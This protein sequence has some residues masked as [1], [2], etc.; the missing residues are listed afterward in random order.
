MIDKSRHQ[1]SRP[2]IVEIIGP[3][4]AGKTTL[5][6]A[7][8]EQNKRILVGED[9]GIKNFRHF[10]FFVRHAPLLFSAILRGSENARTSSWNA[11][12]RLTYLKGW[13]RVLKRPSAHE[14]TLL[15][16]GPIFHLATLYGFAPDQAQ[17]RSRFHWWDT[18][19]RQWASTLDIVVWLDATDDILTERI[20]SREQRHVMKKAPTHEAIKYLSK[21][22]SS[23]EQVV[24][25][26]TANEGINVLCFD[27]SHDAPKDIL[28]QVLAAVN[29]IPRPKTDFAQ[30]ATA[31]RPVT[32]R[33][34]AR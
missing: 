11:A 13:H 32:S 17:G 34:A 5:L 15:D 2:L 19:L 24:S 6:R 33:V 8:C 25:E 26:L 9:P 22:R 4:G 31:N 23:F 21:Y 3:A 30:S 12:K 20:R 27:T 10:P 28:D 16:H 14:V 18:A 1:P 7:L 29:G